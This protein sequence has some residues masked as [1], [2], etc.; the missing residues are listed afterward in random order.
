M[1]AKVEENLLVL[2]D[3][4]AQAGEHEIVSM[5]LEDCIKSIWMS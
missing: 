2:C 5:V 4:F 3:D 1:S